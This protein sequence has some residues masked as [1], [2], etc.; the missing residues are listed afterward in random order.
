MDNVKFIDSQNGYRL[1]FI[2]KPVKNF[3]SDIDLDNIV[4]S[5][6]GYWA[7]VKGEYQELGSKVY[8]SKNRKEWIPAYAQRKNKTPNMSNPEK[9]QEGKVIYKTDPRHSRGWGVNTIGKN[10]IT[11]YTGNGVKKVRPDLQIDHIDGDFT[12]DNLDNLERVTPSENLKRRES[13]RLANA[14]S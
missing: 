5:S 4:Q 10:I 12:N 9:L 8:F 3:P 13:L 7:R 2:D 11:W 6:N 14:E 1:R